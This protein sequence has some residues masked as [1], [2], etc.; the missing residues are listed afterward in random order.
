MKV[1]LVVGHKPTSPGAMN[2]ALGIT[3]YGFNNALANDISMELDIHG[4]HCHIVQR[5]SY[6]DLPD[7]I[8]DEVEPDFIVSLHCNAY[9]EAPGQKEATG[10]EVL[11]Y[12][13]S[14]HGKSMAEIMQ[15]HLVDALKLRNRGALPRHSED[16]GGYLLR[17]TH[18]PCIICEPFFIDNNADIKMANEHYDD[19]V[20][21]YVSAI[22]KI[23]SEVFDG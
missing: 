18:A 8:N 21:A 23:G 14:R 6:R 7:E 3:E 22:V 16:R 20:T 19:L 17:Y 11:Y 9:K 1:A 2:T 12:H 4:I 13:A 15:A 10:T 5:N